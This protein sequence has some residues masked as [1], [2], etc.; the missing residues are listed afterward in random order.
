MRVSVLLPRRTHGLHRPGDMPGC[1]L[2]R[3]ARHALAVAVAV[4][5][6]LLVS[7][8][9][10]DAATWRHRVLLTGCYLGWVWFDIALSDGDGGR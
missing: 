2:S 3:Q 8:T 9:E 7:E 10:P 6:D 5:S 1:R 4:Q